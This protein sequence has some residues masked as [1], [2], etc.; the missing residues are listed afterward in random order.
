MWVAY[1]TFSAVLKKFPRLGNVEMKDR[2][3]ALLDGRGFGIR[4]GG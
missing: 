2:G 1:S 3:R 4:R